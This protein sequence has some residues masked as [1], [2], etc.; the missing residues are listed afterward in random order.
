VGVITNVAPGHLAGV[1]DRDGV[2]NAK[3]EL[4]EVLGKKG[5][6]VLNTD[7]PRV[8]RLAERF[9]GRVI[10]FGIHDS[11]DVWA[12]GVGHNA[13][14]CSFDLRWN[15]LSTHISLKTPG[16]GAVYNAVASAAV[17]YHVGL[18]V[19]D[20]KKGLE[21]TSLVP[22]RMEIID[23]PGGVH[24]IDDTYN[25]NPGSMAQA[26]DTLTQLRGNSRGI[27]I[28][29]DMLELGDY[30]VEAHR[31]LGALAARSGI[32]H[33]YVTGDF[34]KT[35]AEGAR[36]EG[37]KANHV[38]VSSQEDILKELM[39]RLAPGDWVLVKGSRL[40]AMEKIVDGLRAKSIK[41]CT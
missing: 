28:T 38:S 15:D 29:G 33:L 37:L 40:T 22:G 31:Q 8:C 14:G 10:R 26:I 9:S 17:G 6:A 39:K 27:L 41:K 36:K 32:S 11:A 23:L 7:D 24:L 25:A 5:T 13:L 4:L 20:I 2:M 34:A 21:T 16:R 3:G 12:Q 30:S 35:V 1:K 19:K 18:S